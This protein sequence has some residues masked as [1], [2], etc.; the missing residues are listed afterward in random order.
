MQSF[1]GGALFAIIC[2]MQVA[3]VVVT[4]SSRR[5]QDSNGPAKRR[6]A[7]ISNEFRHNGRQ[8]LIFA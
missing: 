2:V 3:A 5:P 8:R 1:M 7:A 4:H 6:S